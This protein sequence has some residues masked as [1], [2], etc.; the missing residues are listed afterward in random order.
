MSTRTSLIWRR[1]WKIWRSDILDG[2]G[3]ILFLCC[4]YRA[5][6]VLHWWMSK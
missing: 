5:P 2:L 3:L 4:A 1:R 6:D